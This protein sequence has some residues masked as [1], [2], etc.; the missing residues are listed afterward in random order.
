MSQPLTM[1]TCVHCNANYLQE[2]NNIEG[3]CAYHPVPSYGSGRPSCCGSY[4]PCKKTKHR[5]V[6]HCE[7]PYAA[8]FERASAING[9]TDTLKLWG[10]CEDK[11][12][13]DTNSKQFCMFSLFVI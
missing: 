10:V 4:Y 11:D 5:S 13:I 8:F 12:L 1:L 6:H 9:Y 2:K 3:I 7:F